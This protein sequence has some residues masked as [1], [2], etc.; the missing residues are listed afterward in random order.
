M[1]VTRSIGSN[2][3]TRLMDLGRQALEG[4][5]VIDG[6]TGVS[7]DWLAQAAAGSSVDVYALDRQRA[8]QVSDS[9]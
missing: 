1:S 2:V 5:T 8:P 7:I 6:D 9:R 3:L 4:T